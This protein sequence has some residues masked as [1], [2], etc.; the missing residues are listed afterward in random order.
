MGIE[1]RLF[2]IFEGSFS[3]A[4]FATNKMAY[5]QRWKGT[6][7]KKHFLQFL[8]ICSCFA[9]FF[10]RGD[11]FAEDSF[12]NVES[13]ASKQ[14]NNSSTKGLDLGQLFRYYGSDKDINGYTSAYHALFDHLKEKPVTVLEIGIGTM[15]PNVPSSMVGYSRPGYKP[16]GSL[17]A[18]RDYFV[19]GTIHG[20]DIQAD[21]QFSDESRITTYICDSTDKAKVEE[22]MKNL[23]NITFDIIVDDGSHIDANQLKTLSNFYPYLKDGGIYIIED[24]YPGSAVSSK[25]SEVARL[26]N[27]DPFFFVGLRN[28]I[29]VIY[30]KHLVRESLSYQY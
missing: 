23:G 1:W 9:F 11:I 21:T 4:I 17:R 26:C 10:A 14:Q 7:R 20:V 28:N 6:M 25:P 24:I 5:H 3:C 16:G 13:V 18:W 2:K 29:G 8:T 22:F 19:N 27:G 12:K 30:K 15:I